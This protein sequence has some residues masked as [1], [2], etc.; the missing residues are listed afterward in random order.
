MLRSLLVYLLFVPWTLFVI[1]TGVPLS[2]LSPD[3]LHSYARIWARVGL[4][5]AGV[6]LQVK[7]LEH[8]PQGRAVIFMPNH[9]SN[10]DIL[11]LFAGLP[12][13]FR[14]LA[15]QELF[16]IPLFGLAMRRTGYIPVDRSDRRAAI[17]SM[18]LAA[19]R[20]AG[21]TSIVLFPEGTRSP[22]G[23]LLPLKK[24][25]FMLALQAQVPIVPVAL[26]GSR[27]VLPKHGWRLRPGPVAV[28]IF[29]VVET[30]GLTVADRERLMDEVRR[31]LQ[32]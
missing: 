16:R 4:W 32:G 2:F 20:I 30:A 9:Q 24:G 14:W 29:P 1:A 11:A 21:G 17:A 28:E 18:A 8:L 22:D 7:G 10:V 31:P 25:G 23:A 13:Q 19:E 26:R 12:V 3:Y 27:E 15:K 5:L 6:R